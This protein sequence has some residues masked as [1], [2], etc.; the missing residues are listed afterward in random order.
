MIAA[1]VKINSKLSEIERAFSIPLVDIAQR[2]LPSMLA[3]FEA[4]QGA[5]GPFRALGA[6]STPRPGNGLFWV[7]PGAPQPSGYVVKVESGDRAGWAGYKSYKDYCSLRGSPPRKMRASGQ[8]LSSVAIRVNG[9]GRVK[10]APYGA[11]APAQK[12]DGKGARS[13]NTSVL[14]AASKDEPKPLFAPTREELQQILVDFQ[15]GVAGQIENAADA[16]EVRGYSLRA[17][18]LE[19]RRL[20]SETARRR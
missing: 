2:L 5:A 3:R 8:A 1:N 13:S 11:H 20:V 10:I 15:N 4:G 7:A 14:Y 6:D 16:Q 18:K 9:P 17:T 12:I 19:K